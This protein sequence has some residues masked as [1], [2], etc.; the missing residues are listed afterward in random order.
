MTQRTTAASCATGVIVTLGA[1]ATADCGGDPQRWS[2]LLRQL[3][4]MSPADRSAAVEVYVTKHGGTPLIENQ[5]RL[6]FLA[7][8]VDGAA[9]RVV[10]DF[11]AWAQ[12]PGPGLPPPPAGNAAS[13]TMTRIEGTDWSY[14]E[15]TAFSNARLEYVLVIDAPAGTPATRASVRPDPLNPRS[16]QS[17]AG[18][19]SEARMPLWVAQPEIDGPGAAP[20]GSI[21]DESVPSKELG[22]ARRVWFYLPPGYNPTGQELYPVAFVLDGGSYV[23]RMDVPRVL[24]RLIASAA[25]PPLIAVFSEPADRQEEYSRNPRWRAFMSK[26]LVPLVDKRFRTFPA[27][28]H[29]IVLG[30]S[31]A[32]YGAVD[33]AIEFPSIFGL[34]AAIAPPAQAATLVAN[35]AHAK[36]AVRSTRFFVLGGLYD[37]LIDGARRLRTSLDDVDAAVKYLE[38]SEGHSTETF[39]GHLD[40]A[41]RALLP[42]Q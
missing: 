38:V 29:R 8:D 13:G 22:G 7:R 33:L 18:P 19:R 25:I 23:E 11:N 15:S 31:L 6:I 27:P 4:G 21:I 26:E 41:V 2:A 30:S 1:L 10:G 9:P 24:D 42:Q 40:D 36:A 12:A 16:V 37:S 32:A 17:F 35:Q 14:L 34:C 28:D 5:T 20:A 39:R 3:G